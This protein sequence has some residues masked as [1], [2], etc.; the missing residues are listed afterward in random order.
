MDT[1]ATEQRRR[2]DALMAEL[3]KLPTP[4]LIPESARLRCPMPLDEA[5]KKR[6]RPAFGGGIAAQKLLSYIEALEEVDDHRGA[7]G[8]R[9]FELHWEG[10][11]LKARQSLD[12]AAPLVMASHLAGRQEVY[13]HLFAVCVARI[14]RLLPIAARATGYKI[15]KEDRELLAPYRTLR[16]YFEH[17]EDR[18]PG[19]KNYV[20][21]ASETEADGEWRF[22]MGLTLDAQ[23]RIVLGGVAMDVSPR[24]VATVRVVLRRNWEQLKPSALATVR[25][26]FEA[27]PS[28]IPGSEAVTHDLLVS[29]GGV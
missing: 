7:I 15:P 2:L 14:E 17:L 12:A 28:D 9:I 19:G 20:A 26:H 29:T 3:E 5:G 22:R 23:Q 25:K 11:R 4:E 8:R 16:D 6:M 24:G 10:S 18:L 13:F 21:S 27:D 1:L